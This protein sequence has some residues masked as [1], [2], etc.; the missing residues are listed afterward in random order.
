MASNRPQPV[1]QKKPSIKWD[2]YQSHGGTLRISRTSCCGAVEL[3]S[4]GGEYFVLRCS[5]AG[6]YEET[7]RGLYIK[8]AAAYL[9]L[10]QKHHSEDHRRGE[11]P[12]SDAHID[13]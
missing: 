9:A 6:H 11:T 12:E 2:P 10:E 4:E 1:K 8:A 5:E 3:A 7:S 13:P